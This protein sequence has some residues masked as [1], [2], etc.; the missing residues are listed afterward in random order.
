MIVLNVLQEWEGTFWWRCYIASWVLNQTGLARTSS[1]WPSYQLLLG[2]GCLA[3]HE[4][5]WPSHF[6][7]FMSPWSC[8]ALTDLHSSCYH[9]ISLNRNDSIFKIFPGMDELEEDSRWFVK[10]HNIL[11][12][13]SDDKKKNNT[14][15]WPSMAASTKVLISNRP[16]TWDLFRKMDWQQDYS[17]KFEAQWGQRM[18][19]TSASNKIDLRWSCKASLRF[20]AQRNP[21]V[22]RMQAGEGHLSDYLTCSYVMEGIVGQC[23]EHSRNHPF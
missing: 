1:S 20:N 18:H 21:F 2:D 13:G 11:W 5:S 6:S 23:K 4:F 15:S 22:I 8:S 10:G 14:E 9:L 19:K 12:K 17:F 3:T 7:S 16:C